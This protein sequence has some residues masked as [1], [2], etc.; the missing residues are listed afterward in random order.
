MVTACMAAIAP[1]IVKTCRDNLSQKNAVSSTATSSTD[2]AMAS[3]S[4]SVRDNSVEESTVE[5]L[6][7]QSILQFI[8]GTSQSVVSYNSSKPKPTSATLLTLGVDYKTRIKIHAGEYVKFSSFLPSDSNSPAKYQYRS[9][10]QDGKLV[11]FKSNEKDPIN[12]ITKWTEAYQVYVAILAEKY[13]LEIGNLMVYTQTVQKLPSHVGTKLL[14][15]RTKSFVVGDKRIHLL[16][17]GNLKIL[18][19]FSNLFNIHPASSSTESATAATPS[20]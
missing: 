2:V 20:P 5:L 16:V 4:T 3:N 9:V 15:N 13:P 1:T 7:A 10:E 18:N 6:P 8:T 17:L 11:F 12:T 19:C 14:F